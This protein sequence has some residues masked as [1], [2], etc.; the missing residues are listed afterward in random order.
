MY[1]PLMQYDSA[2]DQKHIYD[3]AKVANSMKY[4]GTAAQS[5]VAY[6]LHKHLHLQQLSS[7]TW[8]ATGT[9]CDGDSRPS[10]VAFRFA[11]GKKGS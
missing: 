5:S 4:S 2:L 9:D 3:P 8:A 6:I 10:A 11:A 7:S 1:K